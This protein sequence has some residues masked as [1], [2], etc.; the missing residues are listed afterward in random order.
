MRCWAI[1]GL[2][3]HSST[4]RSETL[5]GLQLE[6]M[7]W[8]LSLK[9]RLLEPRL[10]YASQQSQIITYELPLLVDPGPIYH[11]G[12]ASTSLYYFVFFP[13]ASDGMFT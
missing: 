2:I 7:L 8:Y 3:R 1:N 4:L 6:I 13:L 5:G 10:G 11:I 9:A 12:V